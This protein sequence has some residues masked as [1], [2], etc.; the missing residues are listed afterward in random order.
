MS[1]NIYH[2]RFVVY[3]DVEAQQ[4]CLIYRE[5]KYSGLQVINHLLQAYFLNN[6]K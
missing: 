4:T 1:Q 2:V 6:E 3:K 5:D